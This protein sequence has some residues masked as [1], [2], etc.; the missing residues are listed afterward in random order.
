MS[1][2]RICGAR[3]ADDA[4]KCPVCGSSV[5]TTAESLQ[6]RPQVQ[7]QPRQSPSQ[8][9]TSS[10]YGGT[11]GYSSQPVQQTV[12]VQMTPPPVQPVQA[13]QTASG[14]DDF[15]GAFISGST[16]NPLRNHAYEH[17]MNAFRKFQSGGSVSWNWATA[18]LSGLN[19]AYRRCWG[20]AFLFTVLFNVG[21]YC[22]GYIGALAMFIIGGLAGD[23]ILYSRFKKVLEHAYNS[24][25]GNNDAQVGYIAGQGGTSTLCVIIMIGVN[26]ATAAL[27]WYLRVLGF[28]YQIDWGAL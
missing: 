2:C 17:Y 9:Q 3:M 4:V 1:K 21:Y 24:Y 12:T 23:H 25:P 6:P 15:I 14:Y 5:G 28:L 10:A 16:G 26:I 19:L 22:F 8:Q 27:C 11:A 20:K 13:S 7:D 18:I